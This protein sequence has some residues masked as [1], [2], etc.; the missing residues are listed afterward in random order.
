MNLL[1]IGNSITKHGKCSYWPG[2]WGMAASSAEKDYV[3]LLVDKLRRSGQHVEYADI[4]FFKWEIMDHDR[5]EVLPLLDD[6]LDK[7]YDYIIVQLGENVSSVANL[8]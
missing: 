8:E 7:S 4:N 2:V 1:F 3:H 5:D 6:L